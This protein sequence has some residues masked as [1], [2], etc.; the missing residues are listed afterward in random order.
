[1]NLEN[2]RSLLSRI[3]GDRSSRS[4]FARA[5]ARYILFGVNEPK[6]GFP[7]TLEYNLNAGSDSLAFTYLSIGCT[8]YENQRSNREMRFA[9]EKGAEFIEYNHLP[10]V[11]RNIYSKYYLL[12]G[13]LAYYAASQY[14][15]AF[16]VI[17]EAEDYQTDT[18]LLC[19]YFLKKEFKSL[20][21]LLNRIL[22][23]QDDYIQQADLE[24]TTFDANHQ[25][26]IFAKAIASL[27]DY[28]YTG[29]LKS[30]EKSMQIQGDLME[31]LSIENEPSMWWVVRIFRVI[32]D[33]FSKNSL[34]ATI[35]LD[36]DSKENR[37]LTRKYIGNLIFS[38]KSVVELFNAQK[39][40]LPKVMAEHG[41]VVSLP[42]SSGKTQIAA[43]SILQSLL[44]DPDAKVLYLA[45]YRSLAYEVET[46][47]KSTFEK[48]D[49]EVSQLYGTGQ[50]SK[51][52]K[53][54]I[55][56]ASILIATPE[57]AKVILRANDDIIRQI[58]LII[59][60]E[61]HLL[62]ETK[63]NVTNEIYVEELK[64][65]IARNQGKIILLSAVLPN[66]EDIAKWICKDE[67]ACVTGKERLSRQRL[68]ILD[69]K[70]NSVSLQW[71]GDEVSFNPNFIKSIPSSRKGG[72]TQPFDKAMAVAFTALK[73]SDNSKSVLLFTAIAASVPTYAR[74][75]LKAIGIQ[76]EGQELHTWNNMRDWEEFRLVCA[77]YDSNENKELIEFASHGILCHRGSMNKE[78][79]ATIE[80]LMRNGNPR[81]IVATM[82]LGQGVNLGVSTVI[83]ADTAYYDQAK[84]MRVDLKSNEVWNIIGRAG[85]AFQ[86][87]E[88]KVLF[89]VQNQDERSRADLYLKNRPEKTY[90]GL[91]ILL[92]ELKDIA[93]RC[94]V[95]FQELL[96]LIAENDYRKLALFRKRSGEG[97]DERFVEVFDWIDDSLVSMSLLAEERGESLDDYFRNM[98]AYIQADAYG[99]IEQEDVIS[100]LNARNNALKAHILPED[101]DWRSLATSSLPLASAIRL[102]QI[103]P[104]ILDLGWTFLETDCG[105]QERIELLK[106]IETLISGLPSPAFKPEYTD[107]GVLKYPVVL[108]DE[109]R[110]VWLSGD[111]LAEVT[112]VKKVVKLCNNYFGYTITWVLGAIAN[113]C[114]E[115][116]LD[117]LSMV[118]EELAICT[119]LGL[120]DTLA[121]K[122]YL[123]GIK[124][125][126]AAKEISETINLLDL[127]G[128]AKLKDVRDHLLSNIEELIEEVENPL[129]VEW[130]KTLELLNKE[131]SIGK[132]KKI[133]DFTLPDDEISSTRL[134]VKEYPEGNYFLCGRDYEEKIGVLSN[135]DFPFETM[136]NRMDYYFRFNGEVWQFRS[137]T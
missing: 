8:F 43:V 87:I 114:N 101:Q 41:A 20:T 18:S 16:I 32:T 118:F 122:I 25:V 42:T 62:D 98:L 106:N 97:A 79:R 5:N 40:A 131:N 90:S 68:G 54:I 137:A 61:G 17:K 81:I 6:E 57:K 33:G 47:F 69:F 35:P 46:A 115:Y 60:D 27:M 28:L 67:H 48:L 110:R 34:W 37:R 133:K 128:T 19:S 136:V 105:I 119:E 59:I 7:P 85:R 130:L 75:I 1:M 107:K 24:A 103:F 116:E 84:R 123:S 58:R 113:K 15:K 89:A 76:D 11:N 135:D 108:M 65:H 126:I 12:V 39:E 66:S 2:A 78:V 45:P 120:P 9:L 92:Q 72:R 104:E 21:G 3:E 111:S 71:L 50:F 23:N 38:N 121:C 10:K 91:L 83:L 100:F 74:S 44:E 64:T 129:S 63:R 82:T 13:G 26:V 124:S 30:L 88:G 109:A 22:L 51:L 93:R 117:N 102:N 73:L 52:D 53:M 96:E 29:H 80:K 132:V 125:R 14:S 77:E 127:D 31:L 4:L 99:G 95:N 112:D 49:F 134:Y 55:N 36:P 94:G 70:N 56:D 86:D